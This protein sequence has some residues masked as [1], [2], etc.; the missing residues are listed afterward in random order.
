MFRT[1]PIIIMLLTCGPVSAAAHAS[2]VAD[3][4]SGKAIVAPTELQLALRDL[5]SG[6]VFWVR[7]VVIASHYEDN[8]GVE[9]A[10]AKVVENARSIADAIT[11]FYG[12][13]ASDRLF[14]LLAGHYDA[15]KNYMLAGFDENA[16]RKEGASKE[17][18]A[19]ADEI[20]VFLDAANPYLA[21]DAVLPLLIAHGGHHMQQIEAVHRSDFE[22]EAVVWDAM[23]GHVYRIA[24]AMADA[25]A[26]QF[27]DK[28][29]G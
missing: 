16:E 1:I 21:K 25:L 2:Q 24:D 7:S 15:V 29:S 26:R 18:A 17:L 8:A 12:N 20:A 4:I 23:L 9:A 27:P 11:P 14:E 3:A 13:E 22:Q 28:V 6:H 10:E 19:N 5:W